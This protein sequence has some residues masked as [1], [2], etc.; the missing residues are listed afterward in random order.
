MKKYLVNTKEMLAEHKR[1]IPKLRQAGLVG[2]AGKQSKE[3]REI[4]K[5]ALKKAVGKCAGKGGPIQTPFAR[6]SSPIDLLG[7]G[8][9]PPTVKPI[10][11]SA[12]NTL[13]K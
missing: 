8:S 4:K 12:S 2:E 10:P 9:L 6:A 11:K 13:G 5:K 1:I 3:L 7:M